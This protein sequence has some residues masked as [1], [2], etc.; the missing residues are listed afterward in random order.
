MISPYLPRSAL[1]HKGSNCIDFPVHS[2][3]TP[4]IECHAG[5]AIWLATW[6]IEEGHLLPSLHANLAEEQGQKEA[7]NTI[8]AAVMIWHV[9]DCSIGLG[10]QI[11]QQLRASSISAL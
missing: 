5:I 10:Q 9:L 8:V 11:C 2:R 6:P 1:R 3:D 4:F 7:C